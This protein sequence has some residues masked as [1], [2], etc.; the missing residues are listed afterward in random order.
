[1]SLEGLPLQDTVRVRPMLA[2]DLD[3]ADAVMRLAFGTMRGLP[4]PSAAFGDADSV[5]TRFRAAPDCAWVAEVEGDVVGSVFAARW[6]SFGFFGPLS[7]H[8]DLWDQGIG[9]VLLEPVLEAFEHWNVRQAGLFTLAA[10]PKHLALYQKHGFWPGSLTVVTAKEIAPRVTPAP[11]L[12]SNALEHLEEIRE[13]TDQVFRGLDLGREIA[14]VTEQGIGDTVLLRGE[15]SLDGFAVCHCGAGSEAGSDTCYV[16]F[17]A[18]RPGEGAGERFERLVD[19]CEA[20]AA[21]SGLHRLVAGVNTGR[22]DA[23]QRLLASGFRV[24]QIG[25]SMLLRPD[26]PHFDTPAHHVVDDL[27]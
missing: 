17:A 16:K 15:G 25:V 11:E 1:M 9:G 19:A 14:A 7:V 24:E 23:Y 2:D 12:A 18:P 10:S 22:L 3:A 13:L 26:Q 8:P 5:R 4:D 20:Y 6:G 27:R 21:Q